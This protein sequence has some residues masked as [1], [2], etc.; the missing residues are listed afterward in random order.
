MPQKKWQK[1][2]WKYIKFKQKRKRFLIGLVVGFLALGFL[3]FANIQNTSA[4]SCP[5]LMVVFARGS[6][7]EKDTN[8]NFL[9]FKARIEEKIGGWGISREY[10]DLDYEAIGVGDFSVLM[11]AFFGAGEAYDFGKS[12]DMGVKEIKNLVRNCP[13]SKFVLG[14]YSQGAMVVSKVIQSIDAASVVYAATFGDPKIYLPEGRSVGALSI[15]EPLNGTGKNLLHTGSIPAA[16]KGENLSEYRMYVPDCYAY[17]GMLGS[18]RPY[19]P[20]HY[21]GKLGTWCNRYDFFCSSY[22]SVSS[23]TSYIADGLYEDAS[24]VIAN[25]VAESFEIENSYTSPHDTVILIDSTGSMSSLI[26]QYKKEALNLAKKTLEKGGRVALYDYRDISD[27]YEPHERCNFETCNLESFQAGLDGI[28]ADGG[29]DA[30]ESLLSASLKVMKRLDWKYGATK[31]V[32]VLTDTGYHNPDLDGTTFDE[33]VALSKS[34][35]PVNFYVITPGSVMSR[36]ED[37][38]AMTGGAVMAS[39]S[40]LSLLTGAIIARYDSLPR[41]EEESIFSPEVPRLEIIEVSRDGSSVTV[42]FLNSGSR[43]LVALNDAVLGVVEDDSVT[44]SEVDFGLENTLRLI[45][46][47]ESRRGEGVDVNLNDAGGRGEMEIVIPKA[48]NT[49]RR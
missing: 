9:E 18:Y 34:I 37:L 11:G 45:P 14:G 24:R 26:S 15:L 30:P 1:V 42:R 36:Y 46:L 2:R 41:V 47:S 23:H 35:D 48:P 29:G 43:V 8:D 31:S 38:A 20:S 44:I 4:A 13:D 28:S 3:S 39:T 40:D 7:A 17:E 12:V 32:V 33:V 16:C 21:S 6:G 49:G 22:L 25:K 19:Q 5:E 27:N 10:V